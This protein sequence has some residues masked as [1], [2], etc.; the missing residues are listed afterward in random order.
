M[1]NASPIADLSYRN[2]DGPLDSPEFR[3]W[4][5]AK[6]GIRRA[7]KNRWY[8]VVMLLSG[9]YYAVMITI[10]FIGAASRDV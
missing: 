10:L 8:W 7:I 6:M 9:G 3:W 2:Y 4:V 5:I 1:A